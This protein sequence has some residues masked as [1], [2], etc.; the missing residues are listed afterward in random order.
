MDGHKSGQSFVSHSCFW[1]IYVHSDRTIALFNRPLSFNVHFLSFGAVWLRTFIQ[2]DRSL[3]PRPSTHALM[4]LFAGPIALLMAEPGP[5]ENGGQNSKKSSVEVNG[6]KLKLGRFPRKL[7]IFI[8]KP[9]FSFLKENKKNVWFWKFS[10]KISINRP[11][12]G[13]S[14][15]SYKVNS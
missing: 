3:S 15:K 2:I 5:G 6:L 4:L 7:K 14:R 8:S 11:F 12:S 9:E 10:T 1:T 13:K